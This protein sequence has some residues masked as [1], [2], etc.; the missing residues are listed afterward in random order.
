MEGIVSV[1]VLRRGW[2]DRGVL[3]R[4]VCLGRGVRGKKEIDFEW[5]ISMEGFVGYRKDFGF[6]LLMTGR[7]WR[8]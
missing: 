8:V 2:C 1:K 4:L 6:M 7:F 5:G 3:G